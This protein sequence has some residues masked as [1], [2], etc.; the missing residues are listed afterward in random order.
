M[1]TISAN[2]SRGIRRSKPAS[3]MWRPVPTLSPLA[4]AMCSMIKISMTRYVRGSPSGWMAGRQL[5]SYT[6]PSTLN[7]PMARELPLELR[8][9]PALSKPMQQRIL[10][11][12]PVGF[13][14]TIRFGTLIHPQSLLPP[15][16]PFQHRSICK[17]DLPS[18]MPAIGV[19]LLARPLTPRGTLGPALPRR[20]A[21]AHGIQTLTR[22]IL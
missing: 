16:L 11:L 14:A 20:T 22:K 21:D 10:P 6:R 17:L 8:L 4:H 2:E 13:T 9:A 7:S 15:Q 19:R 3:M 12:L 18:A 5:P 1:S